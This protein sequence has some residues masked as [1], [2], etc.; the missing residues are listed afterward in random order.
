MW[1]DKQPVTHLTIAVGSAVQTLD[2]KRIGEV[3]EVRGE[4]FKVKTSRWQRD[5]WLRA[6]RVQSAIPEQSVIL[7]VD[8]AHL[9]SVKI[10]DVPPKD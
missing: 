2:D 9:E 3:S 10:C 1:P 4:H 8:K 6:D 5:F 7:N